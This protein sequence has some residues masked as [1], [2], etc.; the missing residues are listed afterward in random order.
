MFFLFPANYALHQPAKISSVYEDNV[1]SR[2]VD[3]N[4]NADFDAGSCGHTAG[5]SAAPHH[6]S[7]DLGKIITVNA[8]ALVGMISVPLTR[9]S[10][11]DIRI[12]FAE[13]DKDEDFENCVGHILG[14]SSVGETYTIFC[15]KPIRGRYVVLRSF[16]TEWFQ[17]CEVLVY[18]EELG[19]YQ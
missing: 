16:V 7:V 4:G 14:F 17:W 9:Y 6:W 15:T 13:T 2:A 5:A 19:T 10:D 1:A 3:G 11:F 12:G 18:G 8:V